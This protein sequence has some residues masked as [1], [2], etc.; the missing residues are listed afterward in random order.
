MTRQ[1][2]A[3]LSITAA[4]RDIDS[5]IDTAPK[6]GPGS[7]GQLSHF[8]SVLEGYLRDLQAG[9]SPGASDPRPIL[10]RIITDSWSFDSSLGEN[11]ARAEADY[12]RS[13]A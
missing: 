7:T 1:E 2:I 8:R 10:T 13:L 12:I 5:A 9:S 4:L 3:K 6:T 11:I